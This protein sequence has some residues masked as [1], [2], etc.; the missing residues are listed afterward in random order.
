MKKPSLILFCI[1]LAIMSCQ[2]EDAVQPGKVQFSLSNKSSSSSSGRK[3]TDV[4]PDGASLVL[5]L[6]KSNGDTVFTWKTISLLK[7]G[8]Q[9]ITEPLPLPPGS[10]VINDFMIRSNNNTVLFLAPKGGSPLASLVTKPLPISFTVNGNTVVNTEVEVVSADHKNP[11]DFG[12]AAFPIKVIPSS[13]FSVS[14]FVVGDDGRSNL[15]SAKAY[16]LHEQDTILTQDLRATINN[17][18]WVKGNQTR[19]SLVVIKDGYSRYEKEFNLDSMMVALKGAPLPIVLKPAFTISWTPLHANDKLAYYFH[20]GGKAGSKIHV[21]WGDGSVSDY[22]VGPQTVPQEDPLVY[23]DHTFQKPVKYFFSMTGDLDKITFVGLYYDI[24]VIDTLSIVHLPALDRFALSFATQYQGKG[25]DFSRNSKLNMLDLSYSGVNFTS[26]D[27][28]H[29][30]ALRLVNLEYNTN[31]SATVV[32]KVI[33]D[34]FKSILRNN[35]HDGTLSLFAKDVTIPD[36]VGPPSPY[37]IDELHAMINDYG[38]TVYPISQP[39]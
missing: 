22:I 16:I 12:Y 32:N 28:S 2:H 19:F 7:I 38:W 5:S 20:V 26:L 33:D 39:H 6:S 23:V 31:L 13:G 30:E 10:Y 18:N 11:A 15:T 24:P 29:N 35:I 25:I 9:F 8:D 14:A 34:L 3:Q 36:M 4:I 37:Q 1:A 27:L 17:L 21:D